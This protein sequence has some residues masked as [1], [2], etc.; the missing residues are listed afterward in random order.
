MGLF[1]DCFVIPWKVL[2]CCNCADTGR[3]TFSMLISFLQ[4]HNISEVQ[5]QMNDSFLNEK[6]LHLLSH[7]DGVVA[8][9]LDC[10]FVLV[11]T[12]LL[13]A[14]DKFFFLWH[15]VI[16]NS[17]CP[18]RFYDLL[19]MSLGN[20]SLWLSTFGFENSSFF[21]FGSQKMGRGSD[22][23]DFLTWPWP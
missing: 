8:N 13:G 15:F 21:F 9:V 4:A 22:Q 14:I 3:A 2:E 6:Q 16:F 23:C 10:N 1:V 5:V 12:N 18:K 17:L 11:F 19:L 20:V 7:L